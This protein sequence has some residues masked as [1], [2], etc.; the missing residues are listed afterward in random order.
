MKMSLR[1]LRQALICTNPVSANTIFT[2]HS[3][4]YCKDAHMLLFLFTSKQKDSL[5]DRTELDIPRHTRAHLISDSKDQL[6]FSSLTAEGNP[7][8]LR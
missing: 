8:P 7:T 2:S 4:T 6:A 1:M 5:L 3:I